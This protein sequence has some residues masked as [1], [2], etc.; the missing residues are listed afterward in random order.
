MKS[1]NESHLIMESIACL[2]ANEI[3]DGAVNQKSSKVDL[4]YFTNTCKIFANY[5]NANFFS[6]SNSFFKNYHI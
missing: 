2:N 4:Y 6:V 5:L 3:S 1:T